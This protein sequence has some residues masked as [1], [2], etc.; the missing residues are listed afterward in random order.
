MANRAVA[1]AILLF[2][3]AC[4]TPAPPRR[5]KPKVELLAPSDF[6]TSDLDFVIRIDAQRL[7]GEPAI[8]VA[9]RGLAKGEGSSLLRAIL[10]ALEGARAIFFGGRFMTDGFH[11]DGVVA[12]EPAA[13]GAEVE[14][15]PL[16]ESFHPVRSPARLAVFER[17]TSARDEPALE[18][19][20]EGGGVVLA[21]AA[22]ADAVLRIARTGPDAER[23]D[24]P[25]RGLASFAGRLAPGE[26]ANAPTKIPTFRRIARGLG[27]YSGFVEGGDA[28]HVEI[29]LVYG[30][31]DAAAEAVSAARS[32]LAALA[33][34]TG[35]LRSLSD[36]VKLDR[37]DEIVRARA[38]VPFAV[39]AELH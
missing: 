17:T 33:E 13:G 12:I 4:V 18:I 15:K 5:P 21:T 8:D 14:A 11:G 35:P 28:V 22:E 37:Q 27:R 16:D 25:A 31:P 30:S 20:L 6:L 34:A 32:L 3:S 9:A 1:M 36:S 19:V 38:T 29:E 39:V 7:R 23:F 10:P 24:P 2:A 26:A